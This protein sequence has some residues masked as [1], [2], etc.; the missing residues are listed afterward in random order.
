MRFSVV[1]YILYLACKKSFENSFHFF[2]GMRGPWPILL[3]LH[4]RHAEANTILWSVNRE[5]G[6]KEGLLIDTEFGTDLGMLLGVGSRVDDWEKLIPTYYQRMLKFITLADYISTQTVLQDLAA[7]LGMHE[8]K[9][10]GSNP[11]QK[12][13]YRIWNAYWMAKHIVPTNPRQ[14]WCM[15]PQHDTKP[16]KPSTHS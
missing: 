9:I 3:V 13:H 15:S 12:V 10:D 7:H 8:S 5:V 11:R 6:I 16:S 14:L 2:S 1:H 4:C